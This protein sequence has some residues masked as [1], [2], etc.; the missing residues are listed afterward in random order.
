MVGQ[1]CIRHSASTLHFFSVI[2]HIQT[3]S[4][5]N[6]TSIFEVSF[7]LREYELDG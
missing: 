7:Y 1:N 5:T 6:V 3:N 2:V 4:Y